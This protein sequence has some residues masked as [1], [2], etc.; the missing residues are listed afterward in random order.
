MSDFQ[1]IAVRGPRKSADSATR[2]A[3]RQHVAR[4]HGK[5]K[6]L[7]DVQKYRNLAPAGA[8]SKHSWRVGRTGYKSPDSTESSNTTS[9]VSSPQSL[10][11]ASLHDSFSVFPI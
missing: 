7:E 2:K 3:V 9:L 1:F 8:G 5:K 10:L 4:Q 6:R 11:D